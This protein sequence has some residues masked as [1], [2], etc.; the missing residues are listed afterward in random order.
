ML[1]VTAILKIT[2]NRCP[3]S[4]LRDYAG[5]W[6][7][8]RVAKHHGAV[9]DLNTSVFGLW[10]MR[11]SASIVQRMSP[12]CMIMRNRDRTLV[13]FKTK[14]LWFWNLLSFL[15]IIPFTFRF[16]FHFESDAMQLGRWFFTQAEARKVRSDAFFLR[17]C[18]C[19][20]TQHVF[21]YIL[22]Q[23]ALT[24]FLGSNE[25]IRVKGCEEPVSVLAVDILSCEI[26]TRWQQVTIPR[27]SLK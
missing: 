9:R 1:Y 6:V 23:V 19:K 7:K 25:W 21:C 11:T 13:W 2:S 3:R 12:I 24:C 20:N 16:R 10:R 14:A 27:Y 5:N 22:D 4:P 15:L 8:F 26:H 18:Y 17:F